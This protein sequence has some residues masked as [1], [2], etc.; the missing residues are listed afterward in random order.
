M[1]FLSFSRFFRISCQQRF[2][3]ILR[4]EFDLAALMMMHCKIYD[5]KLQKNVIIQTALG[6]VDIIKHRNFT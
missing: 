6:V 5:V 4:I 3:K 1:A 2:L